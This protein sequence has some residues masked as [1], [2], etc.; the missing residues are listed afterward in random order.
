MLPRRVYYRVPIR[1]LLRAARRSIENLRDKPVG[2]TRTR[3]T[4]SDRTTERFDA[5]T[6]LQLSTEKTPSGYAFP[7]REGHPAIGHHVDTEG[8]PESELAPKPH[9]LE[10]LASK[11]GRM[12]Q[13][14]LVESTEW[15]KSTISRHLTQL[16]RDGYVKRVRIGRCKL[17]LFA[18]DDY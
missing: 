5:T 7:P 18:S 4:V 9:L 6:P 11:G 10:L 17:V 1:K 2:T 13:T 14:D 15:S 12:K 16:E 8:P 3:T